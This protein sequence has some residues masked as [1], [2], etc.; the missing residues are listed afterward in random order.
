M[1][2]REYESRLLMAEINKALNVNFRNKLF[3]E[4]FLIIERTILQRK[5]L[6][7]QRASSVIQVHCA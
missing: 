6:Q 4:T 2:P 5:M 1:D 3:R 7:L